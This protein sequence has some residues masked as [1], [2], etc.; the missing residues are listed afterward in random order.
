MCLYFGISTEM[1]TYIYLNFCICCKMIIHWLV[2]TNHVTH[3][4]RDLIEISCETRKIPR[5]KT[6]RNNI[7]CLFFLPFTCFWPC[8]KLCAKIQ[9]PINNTSFRRM[10]KISLPFNFLPEPRWMF[11][12][13][14][15]STH[16]IQWIHS[17]PYF[18]SLLIW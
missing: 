5:K 6:P 9:T 3:L 15:T 11:C 14:H 13:G 8:Y 17:P 18:W 7:G 4:T 1:P 16:C 10:I 12:L 2:I